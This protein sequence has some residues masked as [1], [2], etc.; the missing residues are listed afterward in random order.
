MLLAGECIESIGLGLKRFPGTGRILQGRGLYRSLKIGSIQ[1]A[2]AQSDE[3]WNPYKIPKDETRRAGSPPRRSSFG[4]WTEA[5]KR[6]GQIEGATT[7]LKIWDRRPE[8][9]EPNV[10]RIWDKVDLKNIIH[11]FGVDP[12]GREPHH[13]TPDVEN[14]VI[15]PSRLTEDYNER[16][17]VHRTAALME[18]K[19]RQRRS[20]ITDL[21]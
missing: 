8:A 11:N 10:E 1:S 9:S 13:F 16:I 3:H 18:F 15:R 19:N 21:S 12:A 17:N 4:R 14:Y 20:A 7:E 5:T 6:V 2:R